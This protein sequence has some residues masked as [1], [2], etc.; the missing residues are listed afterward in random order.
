MYII[1]RFEG[2]WV[3]IEAGKVTFSVPRSL[4]P[5]EARTGD[6]LR[7]HVEVDAYATKERKERI[8]KLMDDVFE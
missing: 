1:D 5:K 8:Q 3:V 2:D 4:I 7:I 6:V